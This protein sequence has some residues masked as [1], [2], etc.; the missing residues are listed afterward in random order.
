MKISE[1]PVGDAPRHLPDPLFPLLCQNVIWRNWGLVPVERIAAVLK[2]SEEELISAA[3]EMGLPVAPEVDPRY[4]AAGYLTLLRNNWHLLNYDQL[5]TLL[6]WTPEKLSYTLKEEDFC[7]HKLGL[8][9]PD[10]PEVRLLPR[11]PE[12][13]KRTAWIKEQ[14]QKY[15]PGDRMFCQ[16]KPFAFAD[17][18]HE[19]PETK[20]KTPL[21]DFSFVHSYAAS[22]GD[23]LGEAEH[24]DPVPENL[25]EQY[26]SIGICGVWFHALLYLL[27]PIRGA[28]EFSIGFEKR[29]ANLKKIVE[30]CKKYGIKV[31][32]YF[33]EP[34]TMPEKFY[35]LKPHW[36][37]VETQNIAANCT[38]RSPE[39]LQYLE[40]AMEQLFTQVPELGGIFTIT[41]SE[42][43]TNCHWRSEGEKC[44]CCSKFP[45]AKVIADV[46]A[47]MERGV[48]RAAPDAEMIFYDW[49]WRQ[50]I[51]DTAPLEFK[52]QV[53][54]LLPQGPHC[55][56]NVVSEWGMETR[57]GG[58]KG[59]LRDY[60]ISQV[61]PSKESAAVWDHAAEVGLGCVAKVQL[62]NSWELAALPYL[63]V[64]YL[65][66]EHLEKLR[67]A[68]VRGLMLSWTLGG[69]PGGNLALLNNTPEEIAESTF[70]SAIAPQVCA[71]WRLFSEAFRN[72]PFCVGTAYSAP[73][74]FGPMNLLHL[75]ATGFKATMVGFPYDDLRAWRSIYPE[76]IFENQFAKLIS[77]WN[78]G[79]AVLENAVPEITSKE[80]ES[81]EELYRMANAS[82]CHFNACYNQTRFVRAREAGNKKLMAEY[83]QA[84]LE[85]TLRL[86]DIARQDSRI[87][88][89]ASNHY[90]YSLNDLQEK[91]LNCQFIIESLAESF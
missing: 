63:P 14:V 91:V 33:N 80:K 79:L 47:A 25:L 55:H 53:I 19:L 56:I 49:A 6:G 82:Y 81:F 89:E 24:Q 41:M 31:Y 84:E 39:V 90:F 59:Y 38:T 74:N 37:G 32:L 83:A 69:Y 15:F 22:C 85:N 18:Y 29:I 44:P 86:Y 28:E 88:F 58:V 62:N 20:N 27:H 42:N 45:M 71:A 11:T 36:K 66:R 16:E 13:Q 70:S 3:E 40:S 54:D 43:A 61:G 35:K 2:C 75:T 52:K 51:G 9:K 10:V 46:N 4:L 64:P 12:T 77:K 30:R 65:V 7:W 23:V 26:R 1:L 5:L 17:L 87:G 8:H 76:D 73:T 21:F 48:H 50:N 67:D 57:V 78:E 72:F 34:R 68:G 60:S